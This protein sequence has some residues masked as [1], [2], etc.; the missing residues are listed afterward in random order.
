MFSAACVGVEILGA[1]SV[2]AP[3]ALVLVFHSVGMHYVHYHGYAT[4]MGVVD[5]RLKL[6]GGAETARRGKEVR[7]MVAERAV[8]GVLLYG[9]YLDGVVTVGSDSRQ[10]LGAEL[11]VGADA[12]ALLRHA[13]VAFV[14][15]QG[16]GVGHEI[17]VLPFV[18]AVGMPYLRREYG[19]LF[20]LDYACGVGRDALARASGP[21]YYHFVK[22]AVAD[23]V[24]CETE[25]PHSVV[26]NACGS[27]FQ[28][29][30]PPGKVACEHKRGGVRRPFAE[31]PAT[32]GAAVEAEIV[33]GVGEICQ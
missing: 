1:A 6:L 15:E 9:H 26:V 14:Y 10:H 28:L 7:H 24:G 8:V 27:V 5:K 18:G 19:C 2:E 22:L 17:V 13:Y 23:V 31:H 30:L 11:A 29:L 25:F 32:V 20:V 21:A 16:L 3:D 33:M 4:G 12:L